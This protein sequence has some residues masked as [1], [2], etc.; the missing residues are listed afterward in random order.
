[1][2]AVSAYS[3][4]LQLDHTRVLP[5]PPEAVFAAF[6]EADEL[7]KWWGPRGF[8]IPSVDFAPR[9]GRPY[10]IEMQPP[11][12]EPFYLVGEFREVDPPARLTYT[13]VWE[14]ADP[15]DA[16]TLV[17]LSF[18]EVEGSTEVAFSQGPFRSEERRTLHR[19]GWSE[20]FDKLEE[21]LLSQA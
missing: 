15:D 6:S 4:G 2:R 3:G 14:P 1:M 11:E 13:F 9:V 21:H 20:T 5:V 16:E 12:G 18:R 7:A 10:R 19:D 8:T 17:A